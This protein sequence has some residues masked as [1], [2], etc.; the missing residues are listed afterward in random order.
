MPNIQNDT[1][2]FNEIRKKISHC[3]CSLKIFTFYVFIFLNNYTKN[4]IHV[5]KEQKILLEYKQTINDF[6]HHIIVIFSKLDKRLH[7]IQYHIQLH[8]Q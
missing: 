1:L 3:Q 7:H 6:N 2:Y 8:I 5:L 4:L